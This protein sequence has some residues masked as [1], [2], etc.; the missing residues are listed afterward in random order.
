V[1]AT[2]VTEHSWEEGLAE[3][4]VRSD[5][6]YGL[7]VPAGRYVVGL[8]FNSSSLT[9]EYSAAGL[10]Y[11]D[12][13]PDT[14]DVDYERSPIVVNFGLASLHIHLDLP[15]EFDD[16]YARLRLHRRDTPE[17]AN[18][19]LSPSDGYQ[20][21]ADGAFDRLVS[22]VLPGAYRVEVAFDYGEHIWIPG[23]RDSADSPWVDV[24]TDRT[25]EVAGRIDWEPA[26][27]Q[28]RITGA[29]LDLGLPEAPA[30]GLFSP[31]SVPVPARGYVQG[32]GSFD[33]AWFS[34]GPVKLRVRHRDIDQWI[35]GRSFQ[36]ATLFDPQPGRTISGIEFIESGMSIAVDTPDHTLRSVRFQLYDAGTREL[37]AT[38]LNSYNTSLLVG[39]PN[40]RPGVYLMQ[41][42]S[43]WTE[44]QSWVPQWFDRVDNP[45]DATPIT[46][47]AEGD[48]ARVSV[49]LESAA[50]ST[51]AARSSHE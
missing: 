27:I 13:P 34:P 17:P 35:G 31:D 18:S 10:R 9:Y 19:Q 22:G 43:P 46:I 42:D 41:I 37:R 16:Y 44:S 5:G 48:V 15:A 4:A 51:E 6:A 28:G 38:W 49:I 11:G 30:L 45:D 36:E 32:D 23:V 1:R 33:V 26:R 25:I 7:D 12:A 24:P 29:W 8:R 2:R 21:I 40:L 20:R 14:L 3:V 47:A 39:I 50:R